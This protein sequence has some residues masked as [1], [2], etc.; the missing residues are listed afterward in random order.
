MISPDGLVCALVAGAVAALPSLFVYGRV[1]RLEDLSYRDYQTGLRSVRLLDDDLALLG[2]TEA[3]VALLL[4]DLD[5][6]RRFNELGYRSHG[7]RALLLAATTIRRTL[8]RSGDRIY[9]MHTAG[10]EFLILLTA[11][12]YA[13]AFAEAESV[14]RA[15]EL[16]SV[17]ASIGIA[18]SAGGRRRGA[19]SGRAARAGDHEQEVRQAQR[20]EPSLSPER[21]STIAAGCRRGGV[22]RASSAAQVGERGS[23]NAAPRRLHLP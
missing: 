9:R 18:Y 10:D 17:P 8:M 4:V 19:E 1:R 23:L 14:R 16:A 6:F 5:D 13:Q 2:R 21:R 7:D 12:S 3:P 15:L 20:Q 11:R 22:R